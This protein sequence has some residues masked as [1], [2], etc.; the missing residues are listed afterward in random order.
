VTRVLFVQGRLPSA[1]PQAGL[2]HSVLEPLQFEYLAGAIPHHDVRLVDLRREA[3]GT[4]EAT[5]DTFRPD[6]VG[7]SATTV[8]VSAVRRLFRMVRERRPEA[9]R[10]VGGYH[11]TFRPE[12]FGGGCADVIVRGQGEHSFRAVVDRRGAGASR[13]DDIPGLAL[14]AGDGVAATA[15]RDLSPADAVVPDRRISSRYRRTYHAQLWMPCALVRNTFGCCFRCSFCA[16]WKLGD[17]RLQER[18]PVGLVDELE[19]LSEPNVLFSDDLSYSDDSAPRM[20]RFCDE[21]I[22]RGLRKRLYLAGRSDVVVRHPRLLDRLCEAGMRRM[23]LGLESDDDRSLCAWNKNVSVSRNTEAVRMLQ[24]RGVEVTASFVITPD[25]T[26]ERFEA[27]FAYVDSLGLFCP[28]FLLLTPNPGTRAHL[29]GGYRQVRHDTDLYDHLHVLF[30]TR[31]P[32]AEFYERYADLWRRAYSP[33]RRTGIRRFVRLARGT[34]LP[35]AAHLLRMTW[36]SFRRMGDG[37][38]A[39]EE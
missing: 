18:D 26:A 25:Y 3:P 38:L 19:S 2:E 15:P 12:D 9:L 32:E 21:A 11:A 1:S 30:E 10:V 37:R 23:F 28:S 16:L 22:R 29:D 33:F 17:G 36:K 35:L 27:L 31:L 20:H 14:P 7:A 24:E 39:P 4:L 6:V 34:S 8:D 5:I 13:F